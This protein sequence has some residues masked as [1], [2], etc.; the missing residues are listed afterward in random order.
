MEIPLV[1]QNGIHVLPRG[2]EAIVCDAS[3][4][5]CLGAQTY[6]VE[7]PDEKQKEAKP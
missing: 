5:R 3:N 1:E 2:C 7:V 4:F 6:R